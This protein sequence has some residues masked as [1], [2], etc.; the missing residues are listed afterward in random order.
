[1]QSS[2]GIRIIMALDR[3]S[4][5]V[6]MRLSKEIGDELLDVKTFKR[7]KRFRPI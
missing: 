7:A 2:S 3:V 1:M 5:I 4:S 6:A